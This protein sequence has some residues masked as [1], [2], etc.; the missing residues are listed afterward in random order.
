MGDFHWLHWVV[1]MTIILVIGAA[2][3][4]PWIVALWIARQA[5]RTIEA[6]RKS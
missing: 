4:A 1:V 3:C 2:R 5:R 6:R